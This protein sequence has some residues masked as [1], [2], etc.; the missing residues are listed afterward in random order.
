MSI[1]THLSHK[2]I[3][4]VPRCVPLCA[5]W[6]TQ[7]HFDIYIILL[8]DHHCPET[9]NTWKWEKKKNDC[10][11]IS[12]V[13]R[14]WRRRCGNGANDNALTRVRYCFGVFWCCSH[15][16]T[17]SYVW[18]SFSSIRLLCTVYMTSIISSYTHSSHIFSLKKSQ[19]QIKQT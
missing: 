18:F 9:R 15:S 4:I 11:I 8:C 7:Y 12:I 14:F 5:A 10:K 13:R 6:L 19:R 17:E 2:C 16:I 1:S 3:P